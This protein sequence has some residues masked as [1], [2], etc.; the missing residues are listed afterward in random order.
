MNGKDQHDRC[1]QPTYRTLAL[2]HLLTGWLLIGIIFTGT[3]LP[4]SAQT[5]HSFDPS[6]TETGL[7]L[8]LF[9]MGEPIAAAQPVDPGQSPN[10]D[11]TLSHCQRTKDDW[12]LLDPDGNDIAAPLVYHF[13]GWIQ[14]AEPGNYSF[15]ISTKGAYRLAINGELLTECHFNSP[16]AE[17]ALA[18]TREWNRLEIWQYV[19][20]PEQALLA[21]E[22]KRP[23]AAD[24]EM[25]PPDLCRAPAFYFRPTQP[26]KKRLVDGRDRPGLR[27]KLAGVHPGYRVTNIRPNGMEMPVGGLGRLSDGRLVVARFDA[28]TLKAPHPVDHPN[29]QL[30]LISLSDGEDGT[31]VSGEMIAD[32]LYEPSGVCVI[33]DAILVSQRSEV[34]RYDFDASTT[35]WNPTTIASGWKT[36]DF[37][38]ISA[39]LLF[40]PS[41]PQTHGPDHPGFLY[42]ARSPGLGLMQNPPD[43]GSVWRIDLSRAAGENVTPMTGGHRTPNGIGFG[44]QRELFVI[45]NQGEWTPA[46]E[47]NHVQE[48][49]FYGFYQPHRP[50]N[51]YASPFQP[52]DRDS[53]DARVT[54]P[55][56]QLPQDEIGNSPT[57]PL[58]F[59]TGHRF[60]G[61]LALPDM[62]YG[63]INRVFLE[64]VGGVWQG[65]AMRFTQGLEA[66]PNRILF[67]PEGE[68]Y[69]GGIGGHH[70]STWYWV[71]DQEQPT[72]QGLE[73][74]MPTGEEVFE[75]ESLRATPGGFELTFTEPVAESFLQETTH[76]TMQ[77]WTYQS[78]PAYGG[79]KLDESSLQVT[80]AVAAADGRSVRLYVDGLKQG[81]V[82]YLCT[83]PISN[84]GRALW[85]CEVWY[86]LNQI[87]K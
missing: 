69:A 85:S 22:W 8:R 32:G 47:L 43:H 77:Q 26:G 81:Y 70:A 75:I 73:R 5:S 39:G 52:A 7:R 33:D 29:G 55:A 87:P 17:H 13:S 28:R 20:E 67:G 35:A 11:L 45:D 49:H 18:L 48:G 37:H 59:P 21:L 62:R 12:P 31:Q 10:L 42:M 14:A 65:C 46:N 72:Y 60:E 15:R 6:I 54:L 58:L 74:L 82:V 83:D 4:A 78:T 9:E 50:P 16:S 30:W 2:S 63:G 44:P 79:P 84:S 38:Q 56:V 64:Q 66:G 51:A 23:T 41:D 61:Q 68:L 27:Q 19:N 34:T 24:Y 76:Y 40:Q 80:R 1:T 57:Q 53:P 3:G 86:T 71:N 36:N 25:L